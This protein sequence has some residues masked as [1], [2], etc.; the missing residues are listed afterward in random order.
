MTPLGPFSELK[1]AALIPWPFG[2]MRRAVFY[3]KWSLAVGMSGSWMITPFSSFS[4]KYRMPAATCPH[5]KASVPQWPEPSMMPIKSGF[6]TLLNQSLAQLFPEFTATSNLPFLRRSFLPIISRFSSFAEQ[7]VAAMQKTHPVTFPIN[8]EAGAPFGDRGSGYQIGLQ[9]LRSCL[10]LWDQTQQF[11]TLG[12]NILSFQLLNS[13]ADW[14]QWSLQASKREI[15]QLAQ[16]VCQ[17]A[18]CGCPVSERILREAAGNLASDALVCASQ[19]SASGITPFFILSGGLL[20][21]ST[22]Y[23]EWVSENIR[24]KHPHSPVELLQVESA[25]GVVKKALQSLP[26]GSFASLTK[27][28]KARSHTASPAASSLTEQRN[29][30]SMHLDELEIEDAIQLMIDE[31]Q[32]TQQA[33]QTQKPLIAELIR[34]VS[35][36]FQ[37]EGR[38]FYVGAGTSGRLGVLDASECPPTFGVSYDLVQ[39]II[40][41]GQ[42]ALWR[43]AEGAEDSF[44]AGSQTAFF[45]GIRPGDV[46]I[47]IAASGTTPF[48]LGFLAESKKIG[49]FTALLCFNPNRHPD[50]NPQNEPDI[51]LAL[52]I[53]PEILT[54]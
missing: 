3:A 41:G 13:P 38:L 7:A 53:G 43:A 21:K 47:G 9:A 15:A 6:S 45:R 33:I 50:P 44:H 5:L 49:A 18:E 24:K 54:G 22:L 23:R 51:I 1:E 35:G 31:E 42:E 34:K 29:P 46:V 25:W 39:G 36:A 52:P 4:G 11:P 2:P 28:T 32:Y 48:V 20:K 16:V 12:K 8:P 27:A 37:K 17:S 14:I 19:V 10:T 30:R 40:A 26:Q